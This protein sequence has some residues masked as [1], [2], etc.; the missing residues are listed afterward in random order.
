MTP[1][2]MADEVWYLDY[3]NGWPNASVVKNSGYRGAIRYVTSPSLMQPPNP[4]N[5]KHITEAEYRAYLAAGLDVW[6]VYQGGTTDAESGYAGG[7][8][9]A[10]RVL[11]GC[12]NQN[13][14][15]GRRGPIGYLGPIFFCNDRPDLPNPAN[16]R[17]YLDGAA[18]VLGIGRVGAY[19]F[20]N[21]MDAARG[22][23]SW[24]WQAGRR[25]ELRSHVHFWQDNNFKPTVDGIVC[26]RNLVVGDIGREDMA[27]PQETWSH[28]I[29][30]RDANPPYNV[31]A[32]E[33]LMHT[34]YA[35]WRTLAA[36]GELTDDEADLL[37]AMREVSDANTVRVLEMISHLTPGNVDVAELARLLTETLGASV[38]AELA[39]RLAE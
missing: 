39:E 25:S 17:S 31:S 13:H 29:P 23:A 27:T 15:S 38:A 8:T 16:W 2:P 10:L 35:T 9:N 34:N 22:H 33:M 3:A 12:L 32:A 4:G 6:L 37:A 18:S 11:E 24:F 14:V 5:R 7:R 28:P 19:G 30:V 36:V 21:A 1:R 26:D 20:G